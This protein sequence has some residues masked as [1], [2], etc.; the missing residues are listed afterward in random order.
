MYL[1]FDN[2]PKLL[3]AWGVIGI[4][5]NLH[6]TSVRMGRNKTTSLITSGPD[7]NWKLYRSLKQARY[8]LFNTNKHKDTDV[9]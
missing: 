5:S 1:L 8:S 2:I 7:T 4:P 6:F 3:Y 9:T